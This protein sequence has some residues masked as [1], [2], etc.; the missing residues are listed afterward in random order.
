M[1]HKTLNPTKDKKYWEFSWTEMGDHDAPAQ[2]DYVR[3]FTN[4]AKITYIAHS[5][6]TT[7]MFYQLA[8]PNNNWGNKLNLFIALAPVTRLDHTMSDLFKFF[9]GDVNKIQDALDLIHV[10]H[11][12]DGF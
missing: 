7:Q 6:G 4:Q 3:K 11:A 1:G 2:I 8:K 5:Q 10:Y 12:L 9:S